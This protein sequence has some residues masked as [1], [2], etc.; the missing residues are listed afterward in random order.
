MRGLEKRVRKDAFTAVPSPPVLP[1]RN[2]S[3]ESRHVPGEFWYVVPELGGL[4]A[5]RLNH[6]LHAYGPHIGLEFG[7]LDRRQG[8]MR[9]QAN[10]R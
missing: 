6:P 10:M 9:G 2:T 8:G 4:A 3:R 5:S 7:E 1:P